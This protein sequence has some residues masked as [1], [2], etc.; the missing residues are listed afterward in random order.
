MDPRR[1]PTGRPT[2]SPKT[3]STPRIHEAIA[4]ASCY[5]VIDVDDLDHGSGL[6]P[7]ALA[8]D[9]RD[10]PAF[11]AAV[12]FDS[13]GNLY[14]ANSSIGEIVRVDP[15]RGETRA[16]AVSGWADRAPP[17]AAADGFHHCGERE[18]CRYRQQQASLREASQAR[19]KAPSGWLS[20][21]VGRGT[22]IGEPSAAQAGQPD[23]TF[24]TA[25]TPWLPADPL[26]PQPTGVDRWWSPPHRPP[27]GV[28]IR[29]EPA[30]ERP[31]QTSR[32]GQ[33]DE[34]RPFMGAYSSS[35][36]P[37]AT[38]RSPSAGP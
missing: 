5:F 31:A 15:A 8:S 24:S 12:E 21:R 37:P 36:S 2:R 13:G 30:D 22:H 14:A 11:P 34:V 7:A 10:A 28:S 17:D 29:S 23:Q 20:T 6:W 32:R 19:L 18:Q 3:S 38:Q 16:C 33:A 1:R 27:P 4:A 9:R 25:L 26:T 35:S